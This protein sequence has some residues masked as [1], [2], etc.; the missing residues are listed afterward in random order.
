MGPLNA[1]SMG[2]LVKAKSCLGSGALFPFLSS[3]YQGRTQTF[4]REPP[5]LG[6]MAHFTEWG[7]DVAGAAPQVLALEGPQ[8]LGASAS[9]V[10]FFHLLRTTPGAVCVGRW[11]SR[12]SHRRI[13][14]WAEVGHGLLRGSKEPPGCQTGSD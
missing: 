3:G 7:S 13:Q 14:G 2:T 1:Q 9:D 5:G 8:R 4:F 6:D 11:R 12:G 10:F